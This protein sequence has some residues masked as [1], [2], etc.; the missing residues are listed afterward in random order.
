MLHTETV[1]PGTLELLRKLQSEEMLKNAYLVGGTSLALRLGH[2]KSIDID[3]FIKEDYDNEELA[4][5][6]QT[7]YDF[8]VKACRGWTL[9][10][11]IDKVKIDIISYKYDFV[12]EPEIIDGVKMISIPDI[13]AMKLVAISDSGNRM[14]DFVDIA[15][16]STMY[17]FE[18]M[19]SFFA[20]K[21]PK[22]NPMTAAKGLSYFGDLDQKDIVDTTVKFSWNAVK[23]RLEEM[24]RQ[25][26]RVFESPPL[27]KKRA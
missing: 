10:G 11:E 12:E 1:E 22:S 17:S 18:D 21:Y 16:L 20:Q 2:R 26:N 7:K 3:L 14:K 4:Y 27:E 19:L 5:F 15:Y 25:T 8:Q 23:K 6:L 13:I 24:T 9:K